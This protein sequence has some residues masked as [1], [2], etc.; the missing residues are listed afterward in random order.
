MTALLSLVRRWGPGVLAALGLVW[1]AISVL[2]PFR[3]DGARFGP[4]LVLGALA[5]QYRRKRPLTPFVAAAV[6]VGAYALSSRTL[7]EFRADSASY[8]AYLHSTVFDGDLDFRNE[9]DR[10]GQEVAP[11]RKR[12]INVFSAGPAVVWSPFYLAAHAYVRLDRRFGRGFY[13]ADGMSLPYMR[14]TALGTVTIVVFG[15]TLLFL[16]MAREWGSGIALLSSLSA[17]AASPVLY[18]TF[19]VPAMAHGVTFGLAA[20]LLWAWDR[21]RRHPSPGSWMTLGAIFG[22]LTACRWQAAVYAVLVGSLA[23]V[24]LSKKRARPVW[25]VL[26]AGAAL[27]AF[28]PQLIAWRVGFGDWILIPQGRGFLDFSSPHWLDT[29]VSAD[30]GLFNW[31]PLM[32][33]GFLGLV[34][35]LGASPL[36]YGAGLVVFAL[37]AWVN[38]SVPVFDWAGGDAFGARRYCLVVPLVALG[39]STMLG[40]SSR[41]L[42]RS[43]LLAPAAIVV[44]VAL[45]NLGFVYRFRARD[46]PG[47]APLERLARDQALSLQRTLQDGAGAVAGARG[48]AFVYDVLSG[49]YVYGGLLPG[50]TLFLRNADERFLLRG[51]YTGSRRIA[52]RTFRRALYPE[53][54]ISIP[55]KEPFPLRVEI[56]ASAP[57]GLERQTL[58]LA[59]NGYRVGES[60]LGQDWRE[61]PFQVDKRQLVPGENELCL[62]FSTGL[63]EEDDVSVAAQ[64]EK[65]QFP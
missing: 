62:R 30:H 51:W 48:R 15:A 61:I 35:G 37:T 32:L 14:S 58:S 27:L 29:L 44:V 17:V 10:F 20:A 11:G 36:L 54:C 19:F 31:T 39:L 55:L 24:E 23:F 38:G 9:W 57:E 59:V 34:A 18:Y 64:I 53:A 5:L 43:P 13:P 12:S 40:F 65:I 28:S 7:I 8:F 46:Y 22:L 16:M 1:A 25:I 63:P 21:A 49:E 47:A 3:P 26:A 52:R 56:S 6:L 50:G 33:V 2:D 45:W 42:R 60:P 41:L 4:F